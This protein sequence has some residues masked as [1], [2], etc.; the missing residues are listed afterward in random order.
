MG[1]R[2]PLT[3]SLTFNCEPGETS[4]HHQFLH[5]VMRSLQEPSCGWVSAVHSLAV[6]VIISADVAEVSGKRLHS[7][8]TGDLPTL[9][10]D[11]HACREERR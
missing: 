4:D 11:D 3:G 10:L 9:P 2:I 1:L 7:Q 6:L 5:S 8:G